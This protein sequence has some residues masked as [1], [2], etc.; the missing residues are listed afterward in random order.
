[1]STKSYLIWPSSTS[2]GSVISCYSSR[3]LDS[4]PATLLNPLTILRSLTS[5][6][7]HV[8]SLLPDITLFFSS[9]QTVS[10]YFNNCFWI[11]WFLQ[12]QR[13]E[14]NTCFEHRSSLAFPEVESSQSM[15]WNLLHSYPASLI[16]PIQNKQQTLN[17]SLKLRS[18]KKKILEQRT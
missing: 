16:P 17:S 8:P 6:I 9:R 13:P 4:S 5:K 15:L 2:L 10:W 1:M 14:F 12:I 3:S 11:Y 7:P 18:F